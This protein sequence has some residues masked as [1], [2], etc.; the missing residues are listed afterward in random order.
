VINFAIRPIPIQAYSLPLVVSAKR[1]LLIEKKQAIYDIYNVYIS[2]TKK[3]FSP[4]RSARKQ[5]IS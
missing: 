1:H 2:V 3:T 4:L 5:K